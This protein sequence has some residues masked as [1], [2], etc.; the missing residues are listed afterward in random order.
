MES[1]VQVDHSYYARPKYGTMER[2]ITYQHQIASI[3]DS[4]ARSV[5]LVGVG[6]NLVPYYLQ[7]V[8]GVEVTTCDIDPELNPDIVGDIKSLPCKD[9][10]YD[11]VA[12]FEVLEHLP[13][14]DF[15]TCVREVARVTRKKAFISIPYR[16]TGFDLLLKFPFVRTLL[17]RDWVR[18]RLTMPIKFPGFA[19]SGQHY[20]EIST[21]TTKRQIHSDVGQYFTITKKE[22][23]TFDAYRYFMSLEKKD[24]ISNEYAKEHYDTYLQDLESDYIHERWFKTPAHRFDY[25]Q[26]KKVIMR[27]LYRVT[28][29]QTLEV[30]PGDAV[31]TELFLKKTKKIELLDQS[32]EMI[33]RAQK[34]IGED[35]RVTF[36][37]SDIANYKT[38]KRFD[39]IGAIRCFEYFEDKAAALKKFHSLLSKEGTLVI[40]TKN[41]EHART[42][43]AQERQLHRDQVAH[44]DMVALLT[45]AGFKVD[46]TMS[47]VSRIFAK[48]WLGRLVSKVLH[49]AHVAT[50]G[51]LVIPGI[52]RRFTESYLY[53]ATKR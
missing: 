10:S 23:V 49:D 2:F 14:A 50:G 12:V 32:K 45:E 26:T 19:I 40:V 48:Y 6:D 13:Y 47:A 43:E 22:H 20:W 51:R 4:G 11:A 37:C 52:T 5:L 1:K 15:N 35:G 28:A 27:A 18:M 42:K 46:Y 8:L 17:K 30:G 38:D 9:N 33:S 44:A 36:T 21:Q 24:S 41:P 29:E 7:E 16:N 39:L 34:R 53:V 31:W 3:R 25:N